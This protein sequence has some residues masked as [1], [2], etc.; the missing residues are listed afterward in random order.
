M[1]EQAPTT[2]ELTKTPEEVANQVAKIQAKL[3][4][5]ALKLKKEGH[6]DGIHGTGDDDISY[7]NGTLSTSEIKRTSNGRERMVTTETGRNESGDNVLKGNTSSFKLGE[8]KYRHSEWVDGEF[9][10]TP[11]EIVP[12]SQAVA[13]STEVNVNPLD[14]SSPVA[15]HTYRQSATDNLSEGYSKERTDEDLGAVA[16]SAARVLAH[17]R[18]RLSV[19]KREAKQAAQRARD[20][21]VNRA[22]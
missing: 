14:G 3:G 21:S 6:L 15:E 4:E 12:N 19:R 2:S 10:E 1:G 22:A 11:T 18:S 13:T 20:R 9:V 17:Q 16:G 7:E 5:R 8:V